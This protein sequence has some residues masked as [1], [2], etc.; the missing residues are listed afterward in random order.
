MVL[1]KVSLFLSVFLAVFV[2]LF[3]FLFD[4]SFKISKEQSKNSFI[5]EN[6]SLLFS[7]MGFVLSPLKDGK[8]WKA[9]DLT[10]SSLNGDLYGFDRFLGKVVLV[11]FWAIWC[12]PC[13]KEMPSMEKAYV[14]FKDKGLE[15]LAISLDSGDF[16]KIKKFVKDL[17]LTF[18]IAYDPKDFA[19]YRYG[20]KSIPTTY[21]ID[22]KGYIVAY[23]YGPRE[24]DSN[25]ASELIKYMLT[26]SED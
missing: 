12:P 7:K 6:A 11:N 3:V 4:N 21:L 10:L 16:I 20:V 25:D 19:K 23:S 24:W 22:R 8:K 5:Q 13:V 26:K 15:V 2:I 1:Y 14:K 18:P 9:P 17:K